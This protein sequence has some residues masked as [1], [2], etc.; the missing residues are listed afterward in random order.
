MSW[1]VFGPHV[2]FKGTGDQ[3]VHLTSPEARRE[4]CPLRVLYLKV[5]EQSYHLWQQLSN[6]EVKAT[7]GHCSPNRNFQGARV[8][9][10]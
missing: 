9:Q 6:P 4:A 1:V 2:K 7:G 3:Q 5:Q 8:T 10:L